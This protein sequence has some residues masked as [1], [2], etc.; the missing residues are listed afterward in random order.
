M[1]T[2]YALKNK[3][4]NALLAI[5]AVAIGFMAPIIGHAGG[6]SSVTINSGALD[7]VD[8]FAIAGKGIGIVLTILQIFGVG[9]LIFGVV[10]VAQSIYTQGSLD[11]NRSW[12]KYDSSNLGLFSSNWLYNVIDV[13]LI[14]N[15][16]GCPRK[17]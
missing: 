13:F 1:K 14:N 2:M 9:M 17:S 6:F 15:I 12:K 7:G 8:P 11:S 10:A 4:A 5:E 16:T 3:A